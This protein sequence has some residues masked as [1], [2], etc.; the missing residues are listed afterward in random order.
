MVG[1]RGRDDHRAPVWQLSML[2]ETGA[3]RGGVE[4]GD[5]TIGQDDARSVVD[6]RAAIGRF[7]Q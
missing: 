1:V 6:E 5:Q 2:Q 3:A 7:A 4:R